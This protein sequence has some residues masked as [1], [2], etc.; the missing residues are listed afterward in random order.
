M[1]GASIPGA[2]I[3]QGDQRNTA[4]DERTVGYADHFVDVT[5]MVGP[6]AN[7]HDIGGANILV[8]VPPGTP[9]NSPPIYRWVNGG[10]KIGQPRQG[11]HILFGRYGG[12]HVRPRDRIHILV[13]DHIRDRMHIVRRFH[14]KSS[15]VP[16]GTLRFGLVRYPTDKS[17]GYCRSSLPGLKTD[18]SVPG[19]N[20]YRLLL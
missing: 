6:G 3:L 11:R 7:I 15:F 17:V 5:K 2:W 12:I 16:D 18:M 1:T 10:A 4:T 19:S 20:S 13:R 14:P 9:D 8:F